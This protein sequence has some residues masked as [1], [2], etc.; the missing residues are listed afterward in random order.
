MEPTTLTHLIAYPTSAEVA[1]IDEAAELAISYR[2]LADEIERLA[3]V[4]GG[5]GFDSGDAVALVLPNGLE[6][7][8]LCLALARAGLVAAP[9]NPTSSVSELRGL[10]TE[11]EARAIVT[12]DGNGVV[13]EA[14]AGLAVSTWTSSVEPP[15]V[16]RLTGIQKAS[17]GALGE[18]NADD[19]AFFLHTSG[20]AGRPKVVPLTHANVLISARNIAAHYAL[21]PADRSVVVLPLFHGHGLIGSALATLS[22][23]GT[24]IVPPRFSASHFWQSFRQHRATWYSAVPTI[25]QILLERADADGA[26][27]SGA[28][29][30][31][32]CS[33]AISP[34]VLGE[35]EQRFGAPVVE[36]YGLTEASHQIASN[37][38]P[39]RVRKFGTVGF[40]TGTQIAI[41]DSR[42]HRLP[43]H[44]AGEV[45]VRGP[46]VMR[47]YRNNPAADAAAFVDGWLRTGDTGVVD[48][49]GYLTLTGRIKEIINRGGEKISPAEIEAVLLA[50]PAVAEAVVFGEPDPKYGEEVE[51]AVVLKGDTDAEALRSF[52]RERL[53]DFK[54]PKVIRIV[55]RL[56]KNAMGKVDW[57][58]LVRSNLDIARSTTR[59]LQQQ[60]EQQ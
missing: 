43:P 7:L 29:F 15:G 3:Q 54:V 56:P 2:A 34:T 44:S 14:T 35:L 1:I 32:S 59:N 51:A 47:G 9:L 30:I 13:R 38:L 10:I 8:V 4:L 58:A 46:T 24:V 33:A 37:P 60:K 55:P 21:T 57:R 19:V 42:G 18:P 25:H 48:D 31:R 5:V 22:S 20:T 39:P 11:L 16:V 36:A 49:D 17:R 40:A 27:H 45:V 53:A 50:H 52:C 28:R 41:I 23:G 26:P 6:L 12:R